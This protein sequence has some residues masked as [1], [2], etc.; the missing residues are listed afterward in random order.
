MIV[1]N[2]VKLRLLIALCLWLSSMSACAD[3]AVVITVSQQLKPL[4]SSGVPQL[5]ERIPEA[6]GDAS[7]LSLIADKPF[8]WATTS[9]HGRVAVTV[10]VD[11]AKFQSGQLTVWNWH[12]RAIDKFRIEA[13]KPF[14][15]TYQINEYG[16]YLLTLDGFKD[17]KPVSRLIRSI[18]FSPNLTDARR[19]WKT[20]AFFLG[21]C[22]FP[23][24]YHWSQGGRP[25][26]PKGITE[27]A[28]RELE[29]ELVARLG[30]Q[31]VRADISMEMGRRVTETGESYRFDFKRMD[32]AVKA[33]TSRGFQLA[34]QVMNA[35]DWAILEKYKTV[36]SNGWRYPRREQPQRQYIAALLKRYGEHARFVQVFNEPDQVEFWSGTQEEFVGQYRFSRDQIRKQLPNAP[37]ANGGYAFIDLDKSKYFVEQLKGQVDLHA[38]HSHGNLRELKKDFALMKKLHAEAGYES[39]RYVN[40]ETGYAAWRL[41]QERRQAQ[42]VAQKTLYCWANGHKGVLLFCSRMTRGPGRSGRDFGFLDHQ[43]CPRFVYGTTAALVSSLAGSRFKTTLIESDSVHVYQFQR[44]DKQIIAAFTVGL[45]ANVTIKSDATGGERVDE[46]GNHAKLSNPKQTELQLDGYPRY[47]I[48]KRASAVNVVRAVQK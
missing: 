10:G 42:A 31:L 36:K 6:K 44:G 18:A 22:A 29:A 4:K 3:Q 15:I 46:M 11:A 14:S 7:G 12:N 48:L 8:H 27:Q 45:P 30:F 16:V 9:S 17:G 2:H 43:F 23:G 19:D 37:I 24:R 38:Y 26:L 41:D 39:T 20:D 21:I 5:H 47:V 13:G 33:Y 25:T 28:A 35:P 32:A 34:L 40:T 1:K